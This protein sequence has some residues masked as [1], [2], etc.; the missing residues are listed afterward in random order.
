MTTQAMLVCPQCSTKFPRTSNNQTFCTPAHKVAFY[1]LQTSRGTIIGPL[2]VTA[3]QEW[4]YAGGDRELAK[5]ARREADTLISQWV[6]E[7]RACGRNA[8]LV[9]ARKQ[10]MGWKWVDMKVRAGVRSMGGSLG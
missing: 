8:A 3:A 2:L 1:N 10:R 6:V 4:R 9:V 5:Y 7:D